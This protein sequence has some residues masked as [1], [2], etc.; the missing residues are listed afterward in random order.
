MAKNLLIQ[1]KIKGTIILLWI[2]A[3]LLASYNLVSV[4][5]YSLRPPLKPGKNGLA[6]KNMPLRENVEEDCGFWIYT[7][8]WSC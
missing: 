5:L 1:Y 4:S 2:S 3:G 8:E 6:P 7:E